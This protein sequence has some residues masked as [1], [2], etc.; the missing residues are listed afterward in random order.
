[1]GRKNERFKFVDKFNK[2]MIKKYYR[3]GDTPPTPAKDKD[4]KDIEQVVPLSNDFFMIYEM[5]SRIFR[6]MNL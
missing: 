1:M 3:E 5:L 6:R 2:A 4:N